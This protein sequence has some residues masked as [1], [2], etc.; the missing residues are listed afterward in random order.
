[1]K[2][3]LHIGLPKTGTTSLQSFLYKNASELC[4][5]GIIYEPDIF[6]EKF[7]QDIPLPT[8]PRCIA[9][10]AF[11]YSFL[12]Q[13]EAVA[14]FLVERLEKFRNGKL[15]I[16]SSE[17][18]G[19]HF[20]ERHIKILADKLK[21]YPVDIVMYMRRQDDL[22]DSWYKQWK[23]D[24]YNG[25]IKKNEVEPCVKH[26]LDY[27]AIIKLW[28]NIFSPCQ[29]LSLSLSKVFIPRI[30]DNT[31]DT[32]EDFCS[33]YDI[34]GC[35]KEEKFCNITPERDDIEL[36]ARILEQVSS[37]F[38]PQELRLFLQTL[39]HDDTG[40]RKKN[41]SV[42]SLAER[43]EIMERYAESNQRVADRFF[44][45]TPLFAPLPQT[46]EETPFPSLTVETVILLLRNVITYA[47]KQ[48]VILDRFIRFIEQSGNFDEDFYR[49]TYL[50]ER[51]AILSPIEHFVR[52]GMFKGYSPSRNFCARD[53]W[54]ACPTLKRSGISPFVIGL[55]LEAAE[56]C[57]REK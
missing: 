50:G 15:Y 22:L 31:V 38:T 12:S 37:Q 10:Q 26:S 2:V 16:I 46:E 19:V 29:S 1:M 51:K 23:K 44:G 13:P 36:I 21:E 17:G 52:F 18:M 5:A 47:M 28:E 49:Q 24:G 11:L 14:D 33:L 30:Y 53:I 41:L 57:R 3:I 40:G 6:H 20:S 27:D 9:H 45:G 35:V 32:V 54:E 4:S 34:K 7:R 25:C 48:N 43:H 55:V 56:A 39:Y 8:G 42:Y